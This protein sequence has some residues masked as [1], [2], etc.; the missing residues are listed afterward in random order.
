MT[1]TT[2]VL[3][4][5]LFVACGGRSRNGGGD[6]DSGPTCPACT[7]DNTGVMNCDGSITQC[8]DGMG[9]SMGA[10][11]TACQAAEDNHASVGC[12]YYAVDMDAASG[13]PQQAC[14]TVFVA[15]TSNAVTHID[16]EFNGTSINLAQFAK[17]PVGSG[18]SL[19]YGAYDPSAG[20]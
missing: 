18:K 13:P 8:P 4:V 2:L 17:L 19:T 20:L 10:C 12:D 16:V 5:V 3:S 11:E 14:Y 6:D 7:A 15:N 1:R 9:C